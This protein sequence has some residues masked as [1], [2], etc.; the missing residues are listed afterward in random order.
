MKTRQ[1]LP[2]IANDFTSAEA[3]RPLI[4]QLADKKIVMLGEAS[5]GTH[6][7]YLWRARIS[8]MLIEDCGFSFIA[9]E[10]DWP[11]CYELNRRIKNYENSGQNTQSVLQN[12]ER[13][14]SWMWA[15]WEILE[16][17]QCLQNHN[18]D[19]EEGAKVGFYGLDVYSLYESLDEVSQYLQK[20]EPAAL[21][22][23]RE[24]MRCFEPY[25]DSDGQRY[26]FATR[27]VPKGCS[28]EVN[29]MLTE[30]RGN[31][32]VYPEDREHSFSTEQNAVV[33]KNAEEY[34]R[35]MA[36]GSSYTWNLRDSHMMDTLSRLL[37]FHDTDAKAIV[38][39]HNTHIGDAR[40]TDMARQGLYNIG[41]L[42]REKYGAEKVALIGLGSYSGSVMAGKSWGARAEVMELPKAP[43]D[44]WET[45]C[46][47]AGSRFWVNCGELGQDF[48][49]TPIP[50]RAVGVVYD[51]QYERFGNYVPTVIPKRYDHF[52][53]FDHTKALH[54]MD[55]TVK[56]SKL[57][58]T[59]PFGL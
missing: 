39:A 18:L 19:K 52:L 14:P 49:S 4:S 15:N 26:T 51:P 45:I 56:A 5:H 25:R 53:F 42:A 7:Y 44:S 8:K 54:K 37:D 9:V 21:S 33:I 2:G 3:L 46:H 35:E 27:I 55:I 1:I 50:H 29:R 23:A 16:L 32:P 59:F 40:Y 34:Y 22:S 57:P 28:E 58:E 13:W 30:I 12:F 48:L 20:V 24:A 6:E 10:G 38:W 11:P 43:E 17:A 36:A 47:N 31:M 41:Q